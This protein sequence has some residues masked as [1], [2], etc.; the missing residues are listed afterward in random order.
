[1]FL[2]FNIS[3]NPRKIIKSIRMMWIAHVALIKEIGNAGLYTVL[4]G[5]AQEKFHA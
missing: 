2:N 1:M 5:K 4:V 3:R